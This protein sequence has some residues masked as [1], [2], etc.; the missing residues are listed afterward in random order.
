MRRS[1]ENRSFC[2]ESPLRRP[3][4]PNSRRSVP[5]DPSR[6]SKSEIAVKIAVLRTGLSAMVGRVF[7]HAEILLSGDGEWLAMRDRRARLAYTWKA[8]APQDRIHY[9]PLTAARNGSI[10]WLPV[11]TSRVDCNDFAGLARH[12]VGLLFRLAGRI[13]G[14]LT[15]C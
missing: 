2:G 1:P 9:R 5:K 15:H 3:L 4:V 8:Q 6:E 13:V 7:A 12:P 14:R 10:S 11:L